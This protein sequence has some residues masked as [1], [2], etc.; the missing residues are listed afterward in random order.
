MRRARSNLRSNSCFE[1]AFRKEGLKMN[2]R[3]LLCSAGRLAAAGLTTSQ[4]LQPVKAIAADVKR[5][6]IQNIEAFAV[7][8]PRPSGRSAGGARQR[9][10]RRPLSIGVHAGH[11]GRRCSRVFVRGR[12]DSRCGASEKGD[13]RRESVRG[14]TTPQPR[15]DQLVAHR[16]G[17]VGRHR[18]NRWSAGS[19]AVGRSQSGNAAGVSDLRVAGCGGPN[20]SDAE[21]TGRASRDFEEGRL[22]RHEDPYFSA[23]L[24]G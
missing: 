5:V 19:Q 16:G 11:D 12:I 14:G 13:D 9:L 17:G 21:T 8:V 24:H 20:R 1:T 6:R 22:P 23:E 15:A 7:Q 10:Q 3:E 4:F 18:Q 2:R